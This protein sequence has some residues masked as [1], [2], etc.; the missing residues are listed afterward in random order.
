MYTA[1]CC[2]LFAQQVQQR[3]QF[4]LHGVVQHNGTSATVIAISP[5]PLYQAIL[6]VSLEYGWVVDFEDPPFTSTHDLID[7]TDP[8][9]RASHPGLPGAKGIA[10]GKFQ[11]TYSEGPDNRVPTAEEKKVLE[12]I[13][14]A[15][16]SS[17]NPGKFELREEGPGRYAVVG[18]SVENDQGVTQPVA[19]ILDIPVS[20]PSGTRGIPETVQLILDQVN[21]KGGIRAKLT[22]YPVNLAMQSAPVFFGGGVNVPARTLLVEAFSSSR[23]QLTWQMLLDPDEGFYFFNVEGAAQAVP[24]GSGGT[25]FIP[26]RKP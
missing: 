8:T 19:A 3:P 23:A 11:C 22:D 6:A 25:A 4:M 26:L 12:Q 18:T 20:I 21:A 5:R 1:V 9:W 15:Y 14:S 16:N 13:V 17:G 10:G 7:V 2:A 24:N